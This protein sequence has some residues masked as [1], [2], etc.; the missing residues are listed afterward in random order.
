VV[1]ACGEDLKPQVATLEAKN[2]AL[3]GQ[4]QMLKGE[5]AA[6]ESIVGPPPAFLDLLYP[7]QSLSSS[8][9]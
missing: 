8:S 4:V 2:T 5:K 3:K 9:R 7:P 6:L 1:T